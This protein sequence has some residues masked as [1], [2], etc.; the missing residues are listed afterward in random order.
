M[1]GGINLLFFYISIMKYLQH[2]IAGGCTHHVYKNGPEFGNDEAI[3]I[4][5]AAKEGLAEEAG[6]TNYQAEKMNEVMDT[7]IPALNGKMEAVQLNNFEKQQVIL[8]TLDAAGDFMTE[9]RQTSVT[10]LKNLKDMQGTLM[11]SIDN[12]AMDLDDKRDE[13]KTQLGTLQNIDTSKLGA[14]VAAAD[15]PGQWWENTTAVA[16]AL[17]V[18]VPGKFLTAFGKAVQDTFG[19]NPDGYIGKNTLLAI[20]DSGNQEL[21]A[22]RDTTPIDKISPMLA[23]KVSVGPKK[24]DGPEE[25]L[26]AQK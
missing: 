17:G 19:A 26:L 12:Y 6:T 13:Y 21:L 3:A 4:R 1:N 22:R 15:Q 18:N 20:K 5:E 2:S 24:E 16:K 7:I 25:T 23:Q 9:E 14:L 10:S 8:Q 11:A